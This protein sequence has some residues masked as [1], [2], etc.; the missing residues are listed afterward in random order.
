MSNKH[1]HFKWILRSNLIFM[2]K[3]DKIFIIEINN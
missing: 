1:W 3:R 2:K